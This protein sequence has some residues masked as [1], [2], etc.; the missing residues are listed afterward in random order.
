[1]QKSNR[2][3]CLCVYASKGLQNSYSCMA[4]AW[5]SNRCISSC[6]CQVQVRVRACECACVCV[7]VCA[8]VCVRVCMCVRAWV[9]VH[10]CLHVSNR[11]QG[12][13]LSFQGQLLSFHL[14]A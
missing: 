14:T 10:A 5:L 2:T 12:Q 4:T 1:V 13:L 9:S 3:V 8:C 7:C 6:A 11:Q